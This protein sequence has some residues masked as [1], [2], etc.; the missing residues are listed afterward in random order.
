M[1]LVQMNKRKIH[2]LDCLEFCRK[3]KHYFTHCGTLCAF[4]SHHWSRIQAKEYVVLVPFGRNWHNFSSKL[5]TCF[6]QNSCGIPRKSAFFDPKKVIQNSR[7]YV[8]SW[9]FFKIPSEKA[10]GSLL[11]NVCRTHAIITCSW[12]QT[13]LEY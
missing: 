8:M 13:A 5:M 1:S 3:C 2:F 7:L 10:D 9:E 11:K 6:H 12:L 4:F